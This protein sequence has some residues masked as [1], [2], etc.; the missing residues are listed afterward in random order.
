METQNIRCV[1]YLHEN[2]VHTSKIIRTGGEGSVFSAILGALF[3]GALVNALN[4]L[5]VDAYWQKFIPD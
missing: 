5:G 2:Q 1:K 4:L 3:M